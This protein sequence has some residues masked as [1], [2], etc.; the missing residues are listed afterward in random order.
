MVL[1]SALGLW[2]AIT[3][4]NKLEK[5]H[6]GEKNISLTT[7]NLVN[8]LKIYRYVYKAYDKRNEEVVALK[9][10]I[11]HKEGSGFPLSAVRE[12]KFLKSLSHRNIV[13]LKDIVTSKGCEHLDV[14][15]KTDSKSNGV[16]QTK[17]KDENSHNISQICGNLYLVFEYIEHDL[18]GLI[19][20][21]CKFTPR[22]IKCIIKQLFEVLGFL[23]EKKIIHRDIKSS[24]ILISNSHHV[25]LADFGLARSYVTSDGREGKIDLSN[26]VVTMWYKSPEL[27]LGSVRYSTAVD[28]WS[29]GCVLAE[30]ELGRPLFPG[31][32]ELEQLDLICRTMGTPSES[33]WPGL[34]SLQ[35]YDSFLRNGGKYT[36][37]FRANYDQKLSDP[38]LSL[39]ERVLMMDP[40]K[41]SSAK[42]ALSNKYFHSH[43]LP[44]TDPTELEPLAV[45]PGASLHEFQTKQQ[46]KKKEEESKL[47]AVAAERDLMMATAAA[48]ACTALDGT[49]VMS[50]TRGDFS[51]D[52]AGAT[53]DSRYISTGAGNHLSQQQMMPPLHQLVSMSRR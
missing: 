46:R 50:S 23:D 21:R 47:A 17:S 26:N 25:K 40:M 52:S 10:L 20:A 27:L 35:N 22:S 28:V 24:N 48:A 5:E 9:R 12:I 1:R 15:V 53:L 43:P 14:A 36:T 34:T 30:M 2:R 11:F 18:G 44:P 32:A 19:D 51:N 37:T 31:K 29:A 38:V 3:I 6:T 4:T 39:L 45:T 8:A 33:T 42:N 41:R 49:T 16:D 7:A 13:K